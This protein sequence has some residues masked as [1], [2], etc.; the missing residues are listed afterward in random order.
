VAKLGL[1]VEDS[2]LLGFVSHS[3]GRLEAADDL[4]LATM[5]VSLQRLGAQ[6]D[7]EWVEVGRG[8]GRRCLAWGR[9]RGC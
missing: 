4:Q 1:D 5:G 2:W 7:V 9:P 6:P 3:L 8:G